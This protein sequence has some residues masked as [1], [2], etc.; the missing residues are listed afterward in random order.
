[1][2]ASEE[3][4]AR[5]LN[6]LC[7]ARLNPRDQ[8]ELTS[9]VQSYFV[10]E[11]SPCSKHKYVTQFGKTELNARLLIL[12]YKPMFAKNISFGEEA[13]FTLSYNMITHG[14]F[15]TKIARYIVVFSAL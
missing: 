14:S 12:S 7:T 4:V 10:S 1:M 2:M 11:E 3:E 5:A 8:A 9:F 15:D 6:E 13:F